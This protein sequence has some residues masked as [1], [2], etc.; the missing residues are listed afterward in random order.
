METTERLQDVID[1]PRATALMSK[2]SDQAMRIMSSLEKDIAK[3]RAQSVSYHQDTNKSFEINTKQKRTF[4]VQVTGTLKKAWRS[5]ARKLGIISNMNTQDVAEEAQAA[6]VEHLPKYLTEGELYQEWRSLLDGRERDSHNAAHGQRIK[7]P[8]GLFDVGGHKLRHPGDGSH[9]APLSETVNCFP[10]DT[11]VIGNVHGATRHWYEGSLVEVTFASGNK[12][13]GTP[14]HPVLTPE[15]WVAIGQVVKGG[16]VFRRCSGELLSGLDG[17]RG[18]TPPAFDIDDIEPEIAEVFDAVSV[19]GACMRVGRF[20]V[21]FHGDLPTKDVDIVSTNRSLVFTRDAETLKHGDKLGFASALLTAGLSLD[22]SLAVQL[23]G[24]RNLATTGRVGGSSEPASL[25]RSHSAHS[26]VVSLTAR[27]DSHTGGDQALTNGAPVGVEGFGKSELRLPSLVTTDEI[28]DINVRSSVACHV[29]NLD[30]VHG[31]F[32]ANGVLVHNCRCYLRTIWVKPDGTEEIIEDGEL[33]PS[34][35]TR[36]SRKP[37]ENVNKPR[38]Q[39]PT[40]AFTFGVGNGP[41]RRP[42]MLGNMERA[43]VTVG[44]GGVTIRVGGKPVASAPLSRDTFGN[45]R[46]GKVNLKPGYEQAGIEDMLRQSV[47]A[48]NALP[49]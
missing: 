14:N 41:W 36:A 17:G 18:A 49:R 32:Y 4:S 8:G 7:I 37:G 26:N 27:S 46:L 11:R 10:A 38:F 45:W 29:Y 35:P 43:N 47:E 5:F 19:L 9:G 33:N 48:S 1:L 21:D 12:L 15:G 44:N 42:V 40:R 23:E 22:Q 30:T 6:L 13:T 25:I 39:K 16:H 34:S 31:L 24:A 3:A 20:D 28:V 2:A